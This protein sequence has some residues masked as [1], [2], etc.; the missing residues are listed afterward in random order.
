MNFPD[1]L[2]HSSVF[3]RLV[4]R[5]NGVWGQLDP[6]TAEIPLSLQFGWGLV[7]TLLA[8]LLVISRLRNG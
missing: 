2:A 3:V 8:G 1:D 4:G 5:P 7:V 6:P